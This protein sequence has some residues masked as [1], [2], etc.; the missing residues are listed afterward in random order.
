MTQDSA[1]QPSEAAENLQ[2]HFYLMPLR[3]DEYE[4]L[5]IP[6]PDEDDGDTLSMIEKKITELRT[7]GNILYQQAGEHL[8]Q[9]LLEDSL[10]RAAT[11]GKECVVHYPSSLDPYLAWARYEHILRTRKQENRME[12]LANAAGGVLSAALGD[13]LF[14]AVL[15]Y[16]ATKS[17]RKNKAYNTLL[18]EDLDIFRKDS[19]LELLQGKLGQLPLH[20]KQLAEICAEQGWEQLADFYRAKR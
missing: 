18:S 17:L 5:A 9:F 4:L 7:S 2:N 15:A 16:A 8:A 3:G 19:D 10:V 13:V 11:N 12:L 20:P 1:A 6:V 14:P